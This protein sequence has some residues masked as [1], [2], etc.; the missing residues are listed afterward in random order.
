M[1]WGKELEV[2][3]Y[4]PALCLQPPTEAVHLRG[5]VAAKRA[6][7]TARQGILDWRKNPT[8]EKWNSMEDIAQGIRTIPWPEIPELG[9]Q[10]ILK[11]RE[12]V[13]F[14]YLKLSILIL[15]VWVLCMSVT[16]IM[17][18]VPIALGRM[19]YALVSPFYPSLPCH[20]PY[21]A[22]IALFIF[23]RSFRV[24]QTWGTLFYH[25][26]AYTAAFELFFQV[27]LYVG[28][29]IELC[30]RANA[31]IVDSWWTWPFTLH[32][33]SDWILGLM[34]ITI[35]L[36]LQ[37]HSIMT[38]IHGAKTPLEEGD[39]PPVTCLRH[40]ED[41]LEEKKTNSI[42]YVIRACVLEYAHYIHK[43]KSSSKFNGYVHTDRLFTY[44]VLTP[45]LKHGHYVGA[46][47]A[48][49]WLL[50]AMVSTLSSSWLLILFRVTVFAYV[51]L[52]IQEG[53][54]PMWNVWW[55]KMHDKIRKD[56]YLIGTQLHNMQRM[57]AN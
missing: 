16:T 53:A 10:V 12:K 32:L 42:S 21:C 3:V 54:A 40:L 52:T 4:P 44:R 23:F 15:A 19:L 13:T 28:I 47:Y 49:M 5:V 20:D 25:R 2:V 33:F 37:C 48:F 31:T 1:E 55:T 36:E 45:L 56:K 7:Q 35:G 30:F 6:R 39:L 46:L 8:H 14:Q 11:P 51:C 57:V 24:M 17:G 27:P 9:Y 22:A 43:S 34:I 38:S 26:K 50:A 41:Q 29:V 18:L